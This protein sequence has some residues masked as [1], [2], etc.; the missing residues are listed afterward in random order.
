MNIK[1][2]FRKRAEEKFMER[3]KRDMKNWSP[4]QM[5]Q[6]KKNAEKSPFIKRVILG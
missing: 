3:L 2:F 1:N 4:A 6:F 5:E